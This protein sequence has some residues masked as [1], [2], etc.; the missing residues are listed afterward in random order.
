HAAASESVEGSVAS[1]A[2]TQGAARRAAGSH[3][4]RPGPRC[5]MAKVREPMASDHLTMRLFAPGMTVLHRAG[6]AGLACTLDYIKRRRDLGDLIDDDLP[7]GPWQAEQPPW[8]IGEFSIT[9]RF[10]KPEGARKYLMK[11][12]QHAFQIGADGLMYLP[13][14]YGDLP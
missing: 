13:G 6:L 5:P 12:F 3:R 9:L 10:G 4:V 1:V 11:L 2:R 14:Q 8:E 7:G